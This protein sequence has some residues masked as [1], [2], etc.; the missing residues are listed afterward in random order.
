MVT[1]SLRRNSTKVW[2]HMERLS[3]NNS[4]R[5]WWFAYYWL[6]LIAW[7]GVIFALSHTSGA[8]LN[9]TVTTVEETSQFIPLALL[10]QEFTHIVQ[11]GMLA[12][13]AYRLL[14]SYQTLPRMW[15]LGGALIFAVCYGVTDE[16]HQMFVPGRSATLGD[17]A[18][19]TIGAALG[20]VG[21]VIAAWALRRL[22]DAVNQYR[23]PSAG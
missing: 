7:A 19:D 13:L 14:A 20:L 11:Y 12:A 23:A 16:F 15:T 10:T 3:V 21:A 4:S 6:P 1:A 22:W 5:L 18:L 17:L 8:T 9:T 2:Q